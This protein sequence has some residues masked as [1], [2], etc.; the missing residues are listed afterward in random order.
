[1]NTKIYVGN[2]SYNT[3]EA[4]LRELFS[5]AGNVK[6][7]TRPVDHATHLMRNFAFVEMGTATEASKAIQSLNGQIVDGHEIKVTEARSREREAGDGFKGGFERGVRHHGRD[8]FVRGDSR[9]GLGRG[10]S[11]RGRG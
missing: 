3:T 5:Q 2:L 6:S 8:R 7:V 11:H 9:S 4:D 1:M 10:N